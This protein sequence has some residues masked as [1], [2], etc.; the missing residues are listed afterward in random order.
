MCECG[1][2]NILEQMKIFC[3]YFNQWKIVSV[4]VPSIF[5]LLSQIIVYFVL[6]YNNCI[7]NWEYI[8]RIPYSPLRL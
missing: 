5:G 2:M 8:Y 4:S 3:K 7:G 1:K 6:D